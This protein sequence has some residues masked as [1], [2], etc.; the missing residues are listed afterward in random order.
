MPKKVK[1]HLNLKQVQFLYEHGFTSK[2]LA[3][4]LGVNDR[5]VSEWQRKDPVFKE[6]IRKAK[7]IADTYVEKALYKKAIGFEHKTEEFSK[8]RKTGEITVV[9]VMKY[10]APETLACI[11]W[12]KNRKPAEWKDRSP[13]EYNGSIVFN[14]NANIAPKE[15][16]PKQVVEE[17]KLIEENA[18][19]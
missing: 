18:G 16:A 15:I 10:F 12:L 2:E 19:T 11:F 14:I 6:I 9:E 7:S 1:D 4:F 8:D 13:N 17:V 5:T 3:E